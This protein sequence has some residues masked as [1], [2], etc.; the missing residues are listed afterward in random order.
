VFGVAD[1]LPA[2]R[3]AAWD[4]VSWSTLGGDLTGIVRALAVYNGDLI[5]GG[6]F[7][8]VPEFT[9]AENIAR[10]DGAAWSAMGSGTNGGVYAL[11]VNGGSLYAGGLFTVA[12]GRSS[13]Y[14]ARW[15]DPV[16]A[17]KS[18]ALPGVSSRLPRIAL[19]PNRPNPFRAGTTIPY[20]VS[21]DARVRVSIHDVQGR[22]V[23]TI[24]DGPVSAGD[25]ALAWDGRDER[26]AAAASGAYFVRIL[27]AGDEASRMILLVR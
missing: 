20:S 8:A 21:T 10:W 18:P 11:A 23:R 22:L 17:P 26:G 27:S 14:V 2:G 9:I 13:Y 4:G 1:G 25:H 19:G 15:E 7:S 6:N 16:S 5:A 24:L 12:G 3:I